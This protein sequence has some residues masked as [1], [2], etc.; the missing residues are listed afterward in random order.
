L[1]VFNKADASPEAARLASYIDGSVAISAATGEG[2]EELLSVI[3]ARLRS[4]TPVVHLEIPYAR[5]DV[6]AAV[7]RSGEVVSEVAGDSS[8]TL[9]ARIEV[10]ERDR[11]VDFITDA[12]LNGV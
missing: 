11:F 3:G 7:H 9:A 1:Q 5:G 6:I 12:S 10:A 8:V 4:L 2:V